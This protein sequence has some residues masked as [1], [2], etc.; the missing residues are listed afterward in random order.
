VTSLFRTINN[1]HRTFQTSENKLFLT[2]SQL[3][4][5]RPHF[6]PAIVKYHRRRVFP[7]TRVHRNYSGQKHNTKKNSQFFPTLKSYLKNFPKNTPLGFCVLCRESETKLI[8]WGPERMKVN[9][10]DIPSKCGHR[11]GA[12]VLLPSNFNSLHPHLHC[13]LSF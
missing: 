8:C 2:L 10:N 12:P 5:Y 11:G 7:T 13:E 9:K 6:C 4:P 3:I 1:H